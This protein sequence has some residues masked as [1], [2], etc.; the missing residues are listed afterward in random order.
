MER[1]LT[2]S[3]PPGATAHDVGARNSFRFR[4]IAEH[5][6]GMNSAFH[7]VGHGLCTGECHSLTRSKLLSVRI[8][9]D[10]KIFHG[11]GVRPSSGAANLEGQR[12]SELP[13]VFGRSEIAAPEDGRTPLGSGN[14]E[15]H[16]VQFTMTPLP[17]A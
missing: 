9:A 11:I 13:V 14:A 7:L 17:D 8:C 12:V 10:A 5:I 6:G 1:T 16:E 15:L 3:R 4:R 2:L